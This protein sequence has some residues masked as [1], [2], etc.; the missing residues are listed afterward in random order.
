MNNQYDSN[1]NVYL[2][3]RCSTYN[4]HICKFMF[5]NQT[6]LHFNFGSRKKTKRTI[7]SLNKSHK[8][9]NIK[10]YLNL[11]QHREQINVF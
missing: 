3:N 2:A 6:K 5:R 8:K 4:V 11:N 1:I 7:S 9:C 10:S